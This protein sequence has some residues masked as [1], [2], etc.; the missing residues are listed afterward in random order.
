VFRLDSLELGDTAVKVGF[1][2]ELAVEAEMMATVRHAYILPVLGLLTDCDQPSNPDE[3]G[4]MVMK[5]AGSTLRD[6]LRRDRSASLSCC[7]I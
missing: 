5:C 7:L 1:Q 3:T 6:T 2:R 4:Y